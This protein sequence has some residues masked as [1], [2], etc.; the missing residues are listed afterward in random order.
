MVNP[1]N[2]SFIDV[3]LSTLQQLRSETAQDRQLETVAV[4]RRAQPTPAAAAHGRS[5]TR[6]YVSVMVFVTAWSQPSTFWPLSYC[7]HRH[8]HGV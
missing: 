3:S 2:V 8:C 4:I 1:P 5:T 7:M 6:N